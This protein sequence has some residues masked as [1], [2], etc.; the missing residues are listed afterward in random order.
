M[1]RAQVGEHMLAA[2]RQHQRDP[3]AGRQ[4]QGDEPGCRR[5]Y[6]LPHL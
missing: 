5:Q 6:L 3:L 1:D 4:P 2:V